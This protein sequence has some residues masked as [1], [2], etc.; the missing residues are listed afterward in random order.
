MVSQNAESKLEAFARVKADEMTVDFRN[1]AQAS[2]WPVSIYERISVVYTS[3]N[4]KLEWPQSIDSAVHNLEYG[5]LGQ[6]A[7]PVIR[8]FKNRLDKYLEE[9]LNSEVIDALFDDAEAI[10]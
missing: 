7:N 5:K 9:I 6:P 8:R 10:V 4:L 3:G 2:G 1:Q